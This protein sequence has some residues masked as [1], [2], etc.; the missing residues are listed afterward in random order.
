MVVRTRN[1]NILLGDPRDSVNL[2]PRQRGEFLVDRHQVGADDQDL[3]RAVVQ[4]QGPD[5]DFVVHTLKEIEPVAEP[6]HR[7]REGRDDTLLAGAR[8]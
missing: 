8:V 4:E 5:V 7:H 1:Q 6:A 3:R 2:R